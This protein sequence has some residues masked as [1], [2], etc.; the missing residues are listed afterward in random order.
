MLP[1]TTLMIVWFAAVF[2]F[3]V[4]V[5]LLLGFARNRVD[6]RISDL[7]GDGEINPNSRQ[8]TAG[9]T[10]QTGFGSTRRTSDPFNQGSPG[11]RTRNERKDGMRERM[12]RAGLYN[13]SAM[14]AFFTLRVM[15][16]VMPVGIGVLASKM[17][18]MTLTAGLFWGGV[19]GVA[20]TLAPGFWLDHVKAARQTKIRRALPDALDVMVVCLEGGLSL[21]S[22]FLRISRELKTA[23]PMLSEEFKIV[24]QQTK[25]GRTTGE[26]IR[27][28]ADRFDLEEL[29][30]MA[31]VITQAEQ[32]GSSIVKALQ[33]FADGMRLKRQQ[34]AEEMAHK[35]SV[36]IIFPTL[37]CIFPNVLIVILGPAAIQIYNQ[38]I[39]GAFR[40]IGA[41]P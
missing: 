12:L 25:M 30:S 2:S 3:I 28:L 4:L 40:D 21:P 13:R 37:L 6:Q 11:E 39:L 20:G 9:R 7:A 17:G 41:S 16:L 35:A 8:A 26:A 1:D 15:L 14:V 18:I 36:K 27:D 34:R 32:L 24:Q 10:S 22:A 19:A 29:R 5:F 38:L 33:V 23:H 31:A